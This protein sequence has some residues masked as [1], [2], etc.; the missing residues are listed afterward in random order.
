M[1]KRLFAMPEQRGVAFCGFVL[2][3]KAAVCTISASQSMIAITQD[4]YLANH[5]KI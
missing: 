4:D 5:P 1:I 3:L 2:D